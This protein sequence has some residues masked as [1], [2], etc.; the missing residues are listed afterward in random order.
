MFKTKRCH[1]SKS[2]TSEDK[3]LEDTLNEI[4]K[5]GTIRFITSEYYGGSEVGYT[6]VYELE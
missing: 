3:S 4:S 1:Y 2:N 5:I 6:I